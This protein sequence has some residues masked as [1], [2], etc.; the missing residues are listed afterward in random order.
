MSASLARTRRERGSGFAN[1]SRPSVEG[2]ANWSVRLASLCLKV[3][4]DSERGQLCVVDSVAGLSPRMRTPTG[5][6]VDRPTIKPR[7]KSDD[8]SQPSC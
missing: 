7:S 5:F 6:T 3:V 2:L 4:S 8:G 1:P